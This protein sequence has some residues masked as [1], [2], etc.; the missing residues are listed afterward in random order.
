MTTAFN[1]GDMDI[2]A[3]G[4]VEFK[5]EEYDYY[6]GVEV[7]YLQVPYQFLLDPEG[8]SANILK[9][10]NKQD[11]EDNAEEVTITA[12]YTNSTSVNY[13]VTYR[14]Y[15][16]SLKKEHGKE[17]FKG[18][19]HIK[20]DVVTLESETLEDIMTAFKQAVEEYFNTKL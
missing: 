12:T 13:T 3:I 4:D 20:N 14:G 6:D 9:E 17:F 1:G 16:G 8:E 10:L 5:L 15:T 18:T 2:S 19:L 7:N 11:E